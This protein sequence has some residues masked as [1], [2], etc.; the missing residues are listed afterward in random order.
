MFMRPCFFSI[1]CMRR[2]NKLLDTFVVKVEF[3]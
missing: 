2:G 3:V 1:E